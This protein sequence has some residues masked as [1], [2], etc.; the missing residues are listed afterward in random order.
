[1]KDLEQQKSLI[2]SE[3]IVEEGAI[4]PREPES[5]FPTVDQIL[6]QHQGYRR[7]ILSFTS[8]VVDPGVTVNITRQPQ[9][10]FKGQYLYVDETIATHFQ[11]ESLRV[12]H[13]FQS[14][15]LNGGIFALLFAQHGTRPNLELDLCH[16]Q[17]NLTLEV[18]NISTKTSR[19]AAAIEG[20]MID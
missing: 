16:R 17:M 10:A 3:V 20:Y 18:R 15:I 19:F 8:V 1:M 5:D 6:S 11:I 12:G 9:E 2:T 7:V 13:R 14:A 4:V